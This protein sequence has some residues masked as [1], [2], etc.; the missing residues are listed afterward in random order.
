MRM[1]L[2]QSHVDSKLSQSQTSQEMVRHRLEYGS[3]SSPPLPSHQPVQSSQSPQALVPSGRHQQQQELRRVLYACIAAAP[4]QQQQQQQLSFDVQGLS[5]EAEWVAELMVLICG[6]VVQGH[7]IQLDAMRGVRRALRARNLQG[8]AEHLASARLSANSKKPASVAY[9]VGHAGAAVH[10]LGLCLESEWR[11]VPLSLLHW[12]QAG[13]GAITVRARHKAM[14]QALWNLF[15]RVVKLLK[16]R[17]PASFRAGLLEMDVAGIVY[18][19][20]PAS[21][22]KR[23]ASAVPTAARLELGTWEALP[24][25]Y[26]ARLASERLSTTEQHS[27]LLRNA[28]SNLLLTAVKPEEGEEVLLAN[29]SVD[30]DQTLDASELDA[31]RKTLISAGGRLSASHMEGEQGSCWLYS[32]NLTHEEVPSNSLQNFPRHRDVR[33]ECATRRSHSAIRQTYS[34]RKSKQFH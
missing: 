17:T 25:A 16:E 21:K 33:Y 23:R 13:A 22:R 10:I 30:Q 6:T 7:Q 9:A 19:A 29:V 2:Q 3:R 1:Q 34:I 14:L 20:M 12:I 8:I 24:P 4:S 32:S 31:G 15:V 28:S 27:F 11:R 26:T 5:A 18:T